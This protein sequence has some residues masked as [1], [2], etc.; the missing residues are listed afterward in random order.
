MLKSSGVNSQLKF[1]VCASVERDNSK[2]QNNECPAEI[3]S[4]E[5]KLSV[6]RMVRSETSTRVNE[7]SQ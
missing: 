6:R 4:R 5:T 2:I 1:D 7:K 3:T